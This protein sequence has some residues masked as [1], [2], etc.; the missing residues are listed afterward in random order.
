M[1]G[2][3]CTCLR[4]TAEGNRMFFV[5]FDISCLP[6]FFWADSSSPPHLSICCSSAKFLFVCTMFTF[7][8]SPAKTS[9]N[10]GGGPSSDGQDLAN[11]SPDQMRA[12]LAQQQAAL[13]TLQT[14]LE[15]LSV[16][17]K[18][19]V[20]ELTAAAV[21]E[22]MSKPRLASWMRQ[23]GDALGEYVKTVGRPIARPVGRV[24]G[25]GDPGDRLAY[26]MWSVLTESQ[27]AYTEKYAD[28]A[29]LSASQATNPL[30]GLDWQGARNQGGDNFTYK[31]I[32]FAT[33][34]GVLHWRTAKG[35]WVPE[36]AVASQPC[37]RCLGLGLSE[38][39][40]KHWHF[41]CPNWS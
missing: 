27:K 2:V 11:M 14:K 4:R 17:D 41:Q 32:K 21:A 7:T 22:L 1:L 33:R 31:G 3:G 5:K 9:A 39:A 40:A 38:D 6:L 30:D 12:L 34:G 37:K 16:N 23:S 20:P 8:S 26:R 28:P 25:D 24:G 19:G 15:E 18:S 29:A 10:S 13:A 36:T 35:R